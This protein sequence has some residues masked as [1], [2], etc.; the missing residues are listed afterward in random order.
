M[1]TAHRP[2]RHTSIKG[3]VVGTDQF[4]LARGRV[5]GPALRHRCA[6]KGR[7][8]MTSMITAGRVVLDDLSPAALTVSVEEE[9]LLLDP[10][11]GSNVPIAEQ[12]RAALPDRVRGQSRPEFRRSMLG[13]VTD[14]CT[15]MRDVRAQLTALRQVAACTAARAGT[16]LTAIGATP[17]DEPDRT[18][19]DEPRYQAMI[20]RYGPVALDPALC[21]MRV[22]VG[23][24]DRET[25][26]QVCNHLRL[27]L[28]V[29]QAL[30][31]NSPYFQGVDTGHCSWRSV[32]LR[33]W[34]G[35]APTP[36]FDTAADY[37]HTVAGLIS[38]GMVLDEAMFYWYAR[39]SATSPTVE[40][41][42]GDVCTDVEDSVLVTALIRAAVTTAVSDAAAGRPA[43]DVR[44]CL[45]TAAHWQAARDGLGADL[46]D[47]RLGRARPAWELVDEFFATVSPA[48]LHDGDLDLVVHGLSRLRDSGDGAGR[49]RR[50]MEGTGDIRAML[51]ALA[52]WTRTDTD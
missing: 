34:P 14:V 15:D 43:P 30:T 12:V 17:V 21:G 28:P 3:T 42:V 41:R 40:I 19:P 22:Q 24:P 39:L 47:L 29:I 50:I 52:A 13:L 27:W 33:R 36:Y 9:F 4:A 2:K 46:I 51:A 38:T 6:G 7:F 20:D 1:P 8:R 5:A 10:V 45:V 48:L 32:Q 44:D 37:D 49:Q 25:G 26:V 16:R 23:V 18:V 31:G 11:T 35:L